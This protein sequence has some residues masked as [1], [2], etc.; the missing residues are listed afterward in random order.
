MDRR[1]LLKLLEM[2]CKG[3]DVKPYNCIRLYEWLMSLVDTSCS[4]WI[5]VFLK[6][7]FFLLCVFRLEIFEFDF[8][9]A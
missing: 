7:L 4:A 6:D 3:L 2:V 5:N 9:E 8:E 1:A